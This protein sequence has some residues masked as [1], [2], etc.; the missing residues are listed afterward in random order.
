M[1]TD[2]ANR[3]TITEVLGACPA[4][5]PLIHDGTGYRV[6]E[7]D[8]LKP[9]GVAAVS[10]SKPVRPVGHH[11]PPKRPVARLLGAMA[12]K[13]T[14]TETDFALVDSADFHDVLDYATG[15]LAARAGATL[16]DADRERLGEL[17]TLLDKLLD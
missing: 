16:T 1:P 7:L 4:T 12:G 6:V 15:Q 2:S 8:A 17:R 9:R 10:G 14:M 5:V 11:L 3:A 13:I